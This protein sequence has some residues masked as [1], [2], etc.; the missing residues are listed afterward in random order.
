MNNYETL[1]SMLAYW[2]DTISRHADATT[3]EELLATIFTP[4]QIEALRAGGEV[5][6]TDVDWTFPPAD[7]HPN[8][9]ANMEQKIAYVQGQ[10][11]MIN[12]LGEANFRKV[13]TK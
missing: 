10:N 7:T 13:V 9:F 6:V 2:K 12:K 11:R 5:A 3:P 1:V 8:P 4:A